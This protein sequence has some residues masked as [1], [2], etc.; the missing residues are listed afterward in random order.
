VIIIPRS[1]TEEENNTRRQAGATLI[2]IIAKPYKKRKKPNNYI[3]VSGCLAKKL[4]PSVVRT[5][6][7]GSIGNHQATS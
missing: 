6:N 5:E 2:E 7:R 1:Q 4:P 3:Q